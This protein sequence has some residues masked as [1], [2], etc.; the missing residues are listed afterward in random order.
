MLHGRALGRATLARQL[1]LEPSKLTPLGAVHHLVGLQRDTYVALWS[2]LDGFEPAD[3]SALLEE[4]AVVRI[5]VVRGTIHLVTAQDALDLRPLVQPVLDAELARHTEFAPHL[6]GVDLAPV[7]AEASALLGARPRTGPEL[8]EELA[9][10]FPDLHAPALAYAARCLLP[11]V[12]VP[13]RGV[14]GRAAQ[15]TTTTTHAWLGR[16]SDG[17]ASVGDVVLRYLGAFGPATV[18]DV[19]TWS[20]LTRL[21]PVLE[22]LRPQLRTFRHESG[23]ELFDLPEAPRPARDVP[24]PVRFLPEYDNLLLSH[25]DRSRFANAPGV[26]PAATRAPAP[27]H[28]TVL[29][30][31]VVVATWRL[32][33]EQMGRSGQGP[34]VLTVDALVRL[35]RPTAAAVTAE[36]QRL[37]DLLTSGSDSDVRLA[38]PD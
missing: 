19:A 35:S 38:P 17:T 11:L 4:R 20:R 2:R 10:R 33:G 28:G 7:L 26:T 34:P 37:A 31:G 16:S 12:Q 30:D 36:G 3:L 24:A 21:R 18:A 6:H 14:W 32:E 8:R 13:P 27:V 5:V 15:V 9:R 1:L 23:R 22:R 29:A 25:A